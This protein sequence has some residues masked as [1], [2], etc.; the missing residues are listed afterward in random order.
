MDN[1]QT[2]SAGKRRRSRYNKPL[3]SLCFYLFSFVYLELAL[4]VASAS[5]EIRLIPVLLFS[6]CAGAIV[7]L[8]SSLT[9]SE[10]VNFTVGFC[11]LLAVSLFFIAEYL[12]HSAF[13]TYFGLKTMF[14]E[15]ANAAADFSDMFWSTIARGWFAFPLFLLPALV[16]ASL[17]RAGML[18]LPA[19]RLRLEATALMFTI[20]T[21][22]FGL[23]AVRTSKEDYGVYRGDYDISAAV[24]RFGLVSALRLDVKYLLFGMP[25]AE[26]GDITA[27]QPQLSP[28]PGVSAPP[29][30]PSAAPSEP[31]KVYT[32]NEVYDFAAIAAGE[33]D[34]MKQSMAE[35]FDGQP[36]SMQNEYTG[37]FEGKNIIFLTLE[38]FSPW[39]II[40]E[41]MPTMNMLTTN[42]FVFTDYYHP[43][44]GGS[45]ST[46]EWGNLTGLFPESASAMKNSAKHDMSFTIG[47]VLKSRGYTSL[48]FH[49]NSYTYYGRDQTHENLGYTHWVAI[50]SGLEM[51]GGWPRS[52]LEMLE[53]TLDM[54]IDKQP[55]NIYYMTVSGHANYSFTG[56]NMSARHKSEVADLPYS[57]TVK[58][59]IACNLEVEY[60]MKYLLETLEARGI[61]DDTVIVMSP[62]HYPYG[63]IENQPEN[64][65]DELAGHVLE[66]HFEMY[67]SMLVMYCGAVKTPV[68]VDAPTSSLDILPTLLNLFGVDFD[69]RLFTGR[70]VFSDAPPLVIFPNSDFITDAGRFVNST[71]EF[72][73]APGVEVPDGYVTT[74]RGV[75]KNKIAMSKNV[76]HEDYFKYL[77]TK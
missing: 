21:F 59:F 19:Y 73:P 7:F 11:S 65:L 8:L 22:M 52:D 44:W 23:F 56:N 12:I 13:G 51:S 17:H 31:P 15:G 49:N 10:R 46:G 1:R 43:A 69:S 53:T 54:Y 55:F 40:P 68:V 38:A 45:T 24:P 37:M 18:S 6:F 29:D 50:G 32:P 35:Y 26:A 5:G 36:A 27:V 77:K 34:K 57:D 16:F 63:L 60:A 14:G 61:L 76:Q 30:D 28:P 48:A 67:E 70:D 33:S 39:C 2:R 4:A 9:R 72:T 47:S 64:Y 25:A 66:K 74:M 75:V 20:I 58:A 41:L 42:G 62:D 3:R 71:K